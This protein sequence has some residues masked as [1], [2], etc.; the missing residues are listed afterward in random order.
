MLKIVLKTE[1]SPASSGRDKSLVDKNSANPPGRQGQVDLEMDFASLSE[2]EGATV[3]LRSVSLGTHQCGLC[4]PSPLRAWS[5][6]SRKLC[7]HSCH[8]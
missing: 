1:D 2:G 4:L 6:L 7:L 8:K 3:W 5:L